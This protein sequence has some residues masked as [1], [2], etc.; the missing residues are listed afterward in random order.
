MN[1]VD[2]KDT[3]KDFWDRKARTFPRFEEGEH[4]YEAGILNRIRKHG[5]DFRG[6][7]VLD[8]GC[9]SGMYTIRL[10]REARRVTAL[11]I[12]QQMLDFLRQ[13][14]VTQGLDNIDYVRSEWMDFQSD[15]T[16][17]IVFCSMTPAIQS[18]ESRFQLLRH[19]GR[20]TVF[21]GF[22]GV[23]NSQIMT[24]LYEHYDVTP[25][26]FTNGTDMR[27]WLEDHSIPYTRYPVEGTWVTPKSLEARMDSCATFL[28]QYGVTPDQDH[29][30]EYLARFEEEPGQ[31]VDR[32]D[33]KIDLL[34]WNA[35][36]DS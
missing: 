13:D 3:K 28:S 17:D 34:I 27:L 19:A 24:G 9:G 4:T 23:M 31:Y 10:A 26:V 14:A 32:T 18:D 5:V 33:Y 36:A 1:V 12:S 35:Q 20:W 21:M 22:A 6:S 8:V 15:A 25:K 11:D 29:L 2:Q 16:Y 7:T 30:K